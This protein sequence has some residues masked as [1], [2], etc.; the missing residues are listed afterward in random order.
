MGWRV[1]CHDCVSLTLHIT[2]ARRTALWSP[3]TSLSRE[4]IIPIRLHFKC[5]LNT[6]WKSTGQQKPVNFHYQTR[7]VKAS[8]FKSVL[9]VWIGV[10]HRWGHL[11]SL[12]LCLTIQEQAYFVSF[13]LFSYKQCQC[14]TVKKAVFMRS[15]LSSAKEYV[16][17]CWTD[18]LL[19][20]RKK[21]SKCR[22]PNLQSFIVRF[23]YLLSVLC[24]A[25]SI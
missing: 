16:L 8:M 3:Q 7:V 11:A 20:K 17:R 14:H 10:R 22:N 19:K 13:F 6:K 25:L 18:Y 9:P 1:L 24:A 12:S 23:G 5:L 4:I 2:K 15:E 21:K